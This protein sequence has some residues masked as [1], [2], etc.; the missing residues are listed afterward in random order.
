MPF[1]V[2]LLQTYNK[3]ANDKLKLSSHQPPKVSFLHLDSTFFN[4]HIN[5]ILIVL[6]DVS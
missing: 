6:L 5:D 2:R 4:F 1:P 3:M